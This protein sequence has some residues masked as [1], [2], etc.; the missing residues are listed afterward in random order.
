MEKSEDKF[1][2]EVVEQES[3]VEEEPA[4]E[5]EHIEETTIPRPETPSTGHAVSEENSTNPTTPSSQQ[6]A[7]LAPGE[8]TPVPAKPVQ[9]SAGPVIPALPKIIRRETAKTTP[10]KKEHLQPEQAPAVDGEVTA[11]VNAPTSEQGGKGE[12]KEVAPV[13]ALNAWA[14]P[15]GWAGLFN[16]MAAVST[17]P[18]SESGVANTVPTVGKTNAESLA[19]ALRTFSAV[20]NDSKIA[21]LK[22]RGLVNTGN[23]CYMNSVSAFRL[24]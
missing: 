18:S 5:E 4:V 9:R 20:S 21:F 12:V 17:A 14:K 22:P 16:P 7:T 8:T 19:E 1:E 23:M 24:L 6:P 10:E 13:P 3:I 11:E 15:R 2:E